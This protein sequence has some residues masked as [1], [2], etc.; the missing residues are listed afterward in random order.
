MSILEQ[1][2]WGQH[3]SKEKIS[4]E[5]RV[6]SLNKRINLL[7][8]GQFLVIGAN[9]QVI[10]TNI[11]R[12]IR[13]SNAL[14]IPYEFPETVNQKNLYSNTVPAKLA[15]LEKLVSPQDSIVAARYDANQGIRHHTFL[16]THI[17]EADL[18]SRIDDLELR[19]HDY[20][21]SKETNCGTFWTIEGIPS[22]E[23]EEATRSYCEMWPCSHKSM[24]ISCEGR[25][26]SHATTPAMLSNTIPQNPAEEQ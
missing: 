26:T 21:L 12:Y 23:K 13:K 24:R 5:E 16:K 25:T 17:I 22:L 7:M 6:M 14:R 15:E 9:A 19:V 18:L 20:V 11:A 3:F 1:A 2:G 10:P 8:T 4:Y